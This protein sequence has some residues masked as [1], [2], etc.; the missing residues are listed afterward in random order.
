MKTRADL[1]ASW[2]RTRQHLESAFAYLPP[3]PKVGEDGGNVALY[4]EYLEQNELEL[5]LDELEM[6]GEA[7]PVSAAFW[8]SLLQAALEMGLTSHEERYKG[9]VSK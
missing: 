7:N 5:A 3:S 1:E 4:R 8:Q 6:L 2:T 9:K